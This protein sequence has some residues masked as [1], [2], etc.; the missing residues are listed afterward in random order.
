MDRLA[1]IGSKDFAEQIQKYA[2]ETG[3]Y[4]VVGYFDDFEEKGTIIRS[5]PVLG[6]IDE[7]ECVYK[8]DIF[9]YVF[10]AAGYNNFSFREEVFNKI[11]KKVPFATI[12]SPTAKFGS[13]VTLGK[14][15]YVGVDTYIGDETVVEDNVFI[16]GNT[17]VGHNNHIGAHTY[18]SG[19]FNSAGFCTIGK[20]N[21]V[22]ICVLI[23]DHIE[24]TDDVWIGLGCIVAKNIKQPGK[25][26]S[27]SAKLYKIE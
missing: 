2:E 3:K 20:R 25:Y 13:N 24:L 19:R 22:G 10:L 21:F 12:I 26:M 11:S 17:N 14:G 15:V 4:K 23:A 6:K 8:N 16:H 7:I 1:L 5:L 18:I 9:D 27:P